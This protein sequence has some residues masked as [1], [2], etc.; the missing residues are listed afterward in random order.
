[1]E[2]PQ[3]TPVY[4]SNSE[5]SEIL[6]ELR[7]LIE[8]ENLIFRMISS[9]IAVRY[10]RSILGVVWTVLDP[11]MTMIIMAFIFSVLFGRTKP[12]FPVFLYAGLIAWAFFSQS[13][14]SAISE[15]MFGGGKLLG[16]VY[17]PRSIFS[18]S[19]VGSNFVQLL[20]AI[21]PLVF[22][23]LGYKLPFKP[24]LL[25]LPISFVIMIVFTLGF[26]LL[27]SSISVFFPDF[28]IFYTAILRL[29]MYLSG[30]FYQASDMPSIVGK[31]IQF[32]PT[33]ILIDL[34]RSPIYF[35]KIPSGTTIIAGFSWAITMLIIG[36]IIFTKRSKEFT[37]VV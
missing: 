28:R 8:Y 7:G 4:D 30:V 34:F 27:I 25:F 19:A 32:N 31:V 15:L 36:T 26:S 35:G 9:D 10:K 2:I 17:L 18:V 6:S 5:R 21:V 29:M 22:F 14:T 20:F 11:L 13:T 12:A 16:A 23:M 37:Y 33:Y 1:M 3:S 24:A